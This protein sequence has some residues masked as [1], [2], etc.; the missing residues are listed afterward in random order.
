MFPS[1]ERCFASAGKSETAIHK[2]VYEAI[3]D[4]AHA[5]LAGLWL[6]LYLQLMMK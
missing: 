3:G 1:F 2:L 6:Q 5:I 4:V